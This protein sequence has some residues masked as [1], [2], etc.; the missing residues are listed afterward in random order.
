MNLKTVFRCEEL[1]ELGFE[2]EWIGNYLNL[3][4]DGRHVDCR[5]F[6]RGQEMLTFEEAIAESEEWIKEILNEL[7]E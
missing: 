5:S 3:S 2:I 6:F 4:H 1:S 7:N